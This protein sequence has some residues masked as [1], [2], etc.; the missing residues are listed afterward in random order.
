MLRILQY[1][2]VSSLLLTIF[3]CQ[4]SLEE[5][6]ERQAKEYT[7][8]YCPTPVINS[9]NT[10]SISFDHKRKVYIYYL[11]LHDQLDNQEVIDSN[12]DLL[13]EMLTQSVRESTS[14]KGFL[15]AGFKFEYICRSAKDPKKILLKVVI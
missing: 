12:H 9:T 14:L 13:C 15:E 2:I 11:S 3:S 1:F 5:K 7:H 4:E 10:D 6:A 8:K